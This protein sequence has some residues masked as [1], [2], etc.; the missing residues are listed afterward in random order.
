[1]ITVRS[2]L[3]KEHYKLDLPDEIILAILE[4]VQ[5]TETLVR[6]SSASKRFQAFVSKIDSLPLICTQGE[7]SIMLSAALPHSIRISPCPHEDVK[8]LEV[9]L[10]SVPN[11]ARCRAN[12]ASMF[13]AKIDDDQ[14][15]VRRTVAIQVGVLTRGF[16]SKLI[17]IF[18]AKSNY[19]FRISQNETEL[20]LDKILLHRPKTLRS[21]VI[22]CVK[23]SYPFRGKVFMSRVQLANLMLDQLS[24]SSHQPLG[25]QHE[26]WLE[27]PENAAYWLKK[28]HRDREGETLWHIVYESESLHKL[29]AERDLKELMGDFD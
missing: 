20:C 10:C 8:C 14:I 27:E 26:D 3:I 17:P 23:D 12:H 25:S 24:K 6:C 7:L 29:T 18:L 15:D 9:K 13:N 4:K 16:I 2:R 21:V 19:Y 1:M 5:D 11:I 28:Q 22:S